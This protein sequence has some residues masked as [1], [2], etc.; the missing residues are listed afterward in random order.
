MSKPN[1]L[2]RSLLPFDQSRTLV[3]VF[4]MSQSSWLVSGIAPGI[5]RQPLKKLEADE[6]ALLRLLHRRRSE[7]EVRRLPSELRRRARQDRSGAIVEALK[8]W[9]ERSL[10]SVPKGGNIGEALAYGLNHWDGLTRF[11][12]DGRIEIDSNTVERSIRGLALNRK[13]QSSRRSSSLRPPAL[14]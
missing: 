9:S 3:A 12:D 8:P 5:D 7:A 4:K 14:S 6:S 10:A 2:S 13:R 1:D 11:L